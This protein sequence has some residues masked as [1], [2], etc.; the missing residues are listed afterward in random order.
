M[1]LVIVRHRQQH[2][3]RASISRWRIGKPAV[4]GGTEYRWNIANCNT[5]IYHWDDP[6]TQEPGAMAGP[7]DPGCRDADRQD[8]GAYWDTATNKVKGSTFGAHS[9]RI[10]PI[11]LYDP[12]FYDSG[13]RNGRNADLED[14]ELD[15]VLPR[16]VQGNS[17]WGRIIPIG[18]IRDK[19]RDRAGRRDPKTIRLVQ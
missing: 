2:H 3:R 12:I 9:P 10:F 13:K 18:G 16:G 15:R 4:T 11:P 5:T 1:R 17:I 19:K 14:R 6:L 7:D 8:P